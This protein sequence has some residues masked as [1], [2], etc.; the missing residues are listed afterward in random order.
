MEKC[1]ATLNFSVGAFL[2]SALKRYMYN[3]QESQPDTGN[4]ASSPATRLTVQ[5]AA[6]LELGK[7]ANYDSLPPKMPQPAGIY[8][9]IGKKQIYHSSSLIKPAIPLQRNELYAPVV[10]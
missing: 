5:Q 10:L 1:S 8:F 6:F 2:K 7:I 4:S 9:R 3:S